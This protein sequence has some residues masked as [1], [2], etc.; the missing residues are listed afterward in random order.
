M[1]R[2]YAVNDLALR[3]TEGELVFERLL[4]TSIHLTSS[5]TELVEYPELPTVYVYA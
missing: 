2:Y 5:L 4:A 1:T 3:H